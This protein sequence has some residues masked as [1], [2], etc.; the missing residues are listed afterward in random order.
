MHY[1]QAPGQEYSS[2]DRILFRN[3]DYTNINWFGFW[4]TNCLFILLCIA[5]YMIER[6]HKVTKVTL[7]FHATCAKCLA[8]KLVLAAK[9]LK[10]FILNRKLRNGS[11]WRD[12][13]SSCRVWFIRTWFILTTR[14]RLFSQGADLLHGGSQFGVE[15]VAVGSI[16][17][18]NSGR[19]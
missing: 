9:T 7:K 6:L 15:D 17:L 3:A 13:L 2:C 12:G 14:Q 19:R 4:C 1:S 11:R 8:R 18:R 10:S 5:S 16:A